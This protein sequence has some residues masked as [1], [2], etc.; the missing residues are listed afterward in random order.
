MSEVSLREYLEK[1]VCDLDKRLDERF[2]ARDKARALQASEYE[3]RLSDLNHEQ[4]RLAADRERFM[5]REI[6]DTRQRDYELWKAIIDKTIAT[7]QGRATVTTVVMSALIS[8]AIFAVSRL[9]H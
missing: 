6:A 8:A 3:R 7:A 1:Q 2:C 4:A 9:F 5:P